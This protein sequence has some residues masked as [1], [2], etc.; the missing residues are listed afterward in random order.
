MERKLYDINGKEIKLN[1]IVVVSNLNFYPYEYKLIKNKEDIL[2]FKG[3]NGD[4][5]DKE[6]I[7]YQKRVDR[8]YF[9]VKNQKE[10]I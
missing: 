9:V 2:V 1:S 7:A 8:N 3:L 5:K 4:E 10:D 6:Y